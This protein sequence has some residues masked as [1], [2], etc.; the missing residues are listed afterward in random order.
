MTGGDKNF[1][2]INGDDMEARVIQMILLGVAVATVGV[3][4]LGKK[5]WH[6][7]TRNLYA[8]LRQAQS[9]STCKTVDFSELTPLPSPVQRYF[10]HV[11]KQGQPI[12]QSV[13]LR[14][15]GAFN[16]GNDQERWK[17]FTSEQR[18][19]T[20]PPGFVWNARVQMLPGMSVYVHDAYIAGEG[21][22]HAAMLG[23][24]EVAALRGKE[25]IAK[26]ELMRFLAEAVWYPT[27]L[28]PRQGLVW[29]AANESAAKAIL[30]EGNL[31]LTLLFDFNAEGLIDTV[32]A[33]TRGRTVA[34]KIIPTPWEGRFW[35]YRTHHGM[36]IPFAAEASWLLPAGRS[37]YWRGRLTQLTYGL[38]S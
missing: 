10:Q 28:L 15:Y 23:W 35:D 22:L 2:P 29:E 9:P 37:P 7:K 20:T 21:I 38:A 33:E 4:Q 32:T 8:R 3:I 31:T 12:V 24:F 16:V 11:L 27:A 34:D 30:T 19:V 18:V 17:P 13:T 1:S 5:Y 26:G 36:R 6:A 25:E 14:H